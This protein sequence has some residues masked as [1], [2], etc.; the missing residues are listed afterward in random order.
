[1]NSGWELLTPA[2]YE[3]IRSIARARMARQPAGHTLQPTALAHEALSKLLGSE[4]RAQDEK[5]FIAVA[6]EAM[7][8]VIINHA[9]DRSALKRGGGTQPIPLSGMEAWASIGLSPD[10]LLD[11]N[12]VIAEFEDS[13]PELCNIVKMRAFAG[14]SRDE[15]AAVLGIS[16]KTVDRSWRLATALLRRRMNG[17][18]AE[19]EKG[20]DDLGEHAA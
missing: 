6:S 2:V 19:L 15:V 11:L 12:D 18:A 7:R 17:S 5:H 13:E 20:H 16:T 14:L 8:Q 1:M 10:V 3:A 4:F 9:R